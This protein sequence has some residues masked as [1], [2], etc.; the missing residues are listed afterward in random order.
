MAQLER[1]VLATPAVDHG[2]NRLSRGAL[3]TIGVIVFVGALFSATLIISQ[4][5]GATGVDAGTRAAEVVDGWM[6]A[7]TAAN[8]AASEAATLGEARGTQDGWSSALLKPETEVTDGWAAAL[9]KPEAAITD[10]W[11]VRYLAS[12]DE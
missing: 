10:G 9:L 11:A 12:D 8:R 4:G 5:T 1:S 6:P 3:M 7:V 2:G